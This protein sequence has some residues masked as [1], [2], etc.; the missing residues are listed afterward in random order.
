MLELSGIVVDVD[1]NFCRRLPIQLSIEI[2]GGNFEP[3]AGESTVTY[4]LFLNGVYESVLEEILEAQDKN[5]GLVCYLQPYSSD[6][7]V[8]LSKEPPTPSSPITLYASTTGLLRAVTYSATIVGWENKANIDASRL[9]AL[10]A[11][12]EKY[13]PDEKKIYLEVNGNPR[14]NLIAITSMRRLPA[15]LHVSSFRKLSNGEPLKP[16]TTSGGWSY[17]D[18]VPE[19]IVEI[20]Q[21]VVAEKLR[22]QLK[23][24]VNESRVL[25]S[26]DRAKR[27]LEA[28]KLPQE[29]QT[30][31]RSF[32][33]NADVVAQVLERA[34]GVCERCSSD[35]PFIRASDRTPFLE[36]HHKKTLAAGGEDTVENAI[37]V[38]PN[39]HR[40][41][42]FGALNS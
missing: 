18:P 30:I 38:C 36:V 1:Q 25:S 6:A 29:V 42:H 34:D 37:A 33:R 19:W 35:A 15:P 41:L 40:E 8:K 7:I 9:D 27:L 32:R 24:S 2:F 20:D 17:V 10:N 22:E 28:P 3:F 13:Q 12:V 16:K 23:Q 31:S 39:C 14:T 21:T 26:A 11:H 5:K 4:A